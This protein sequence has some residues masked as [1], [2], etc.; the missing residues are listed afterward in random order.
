MIAAS[1]MEDSLL[2]SHAARSNVSLPQIESVSTSWFSSPTTDIVTEI[3]SSPLTA[4]D[5]LKRGRV[6]EAHRAQYAANAQC[7]DGLAIRPALHSDAGGIYAV[8]DGHS[9]QTTMQ[10][11]SEQF[12]DYLE[13]YKQQYDFPEILNERP[14]ID[15]DQHLLYYWS[16]VKNSLTS[17]IPGACAVVSHV[18]GDVIRTASVGDCRAVVG[19]RAT[20]LE[21]T[22]PTGSDVASLNCY[23]TVTALSAGLLPADPHVPRPVHLV[24]GKAKLKDPMGADASTPPFSA[25]ELSIVHQIDLN[26]YEKERLLSEHPGETDVISRDRVKG[27]LQPTRAF[28]DGAYKTQAVME[29]KMRSRGRAAK[30]VWTPPYV[31]AEPDITEYQMHPNDEFMVLSSD[32]LY[33]TLHP[34]QVVE[35]VATFIHSPSL[36]KTYKGNCASYLIERALYADCESVVGRNKKDTTLGWLRLVDRSIRRHLHDD[37]TVQVLFFSPPGKTT[38]TLSEGFTPDV[39]TGEKVGRPQVLQDVLTSLGHST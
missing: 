2:V 20:P 8:F 35:A 18:K 4:V 30:N 26:P 16:R 7:E 5:I 32:G 10:F 11:L 3:S 12:I 19:R 37:I 17:A 13:F 25:I 22:S 9:G 28:G 27:S 31:T 38:P 24:R 21:V 14:F 39:A 36:Q 15:A 23:D 1:T 34:N 6:R 29:A 33:S